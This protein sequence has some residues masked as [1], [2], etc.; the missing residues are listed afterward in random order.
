MPLLYCNPKKHLLFC[1]KIDDHMRHGDAFKALVATFGACVGMG[2]ML[3][4]T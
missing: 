3:W 1:I 2:S 4:V